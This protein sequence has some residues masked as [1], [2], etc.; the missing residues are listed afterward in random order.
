MEM[1]GLAIQQM[2]LI[3]MLVVMLSIGAMII[4]SNFLF[5]EEKGKF[6]DIFEKGILFTDGS[7][8]ISWV[9]YG[10]QAGNKYDYE[11]QVL[12]LN[13][14]FKLEDK[15]DELDFVAVADFKNSLALGTLYSSYDSRILTYPEDRDAELNFRMVSDE[16]PVQGELVHLTLWEYNEC[17]DDFFKGELYSEKPLSELIKKCPG[18]YISSFDVGSEWKGKAFYV[19]LDFTGLELY[20]FHLTNDPYYDDIDTCG[21]WK[22][23]INIP[24]NNCLILTNEED[25]VAI[26][27]S[28][29]ECALTLAR[30]GSLI[31]PA[32]SNIKQGLADYS[33]HDCRDADDACDILDL[34]WTDTNEDHCKDCELAEKTDKYNWRPA[35]ELICSENGYWSVCDGSAEKTNTELTIDNI[36]YKCQDNR[37]VSE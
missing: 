25:G 9:K 29:D 24:E 35:Y 28:G 18:F 11:F 20:E 27:P 23:N 8:R 12:D 4:L 17:I 26:F 10:E 21:D 1:K 13:I 22:N 34:D 32:D 6:T 31:L 7:E 37:W 30:P 5:T 2:L 15:Y 19:Q 3:V 16:K 14:G 33:D 36:N